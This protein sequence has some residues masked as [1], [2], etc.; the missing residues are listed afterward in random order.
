M[1]WCEDNGEAFI[2]GLPGNSVL[3]AM[4]E[5]A[6]DHL[7]LWHAV[8]TEAKLRCYTSLE[9]KARSWRGQSLQG[10]TP[11]RLGRP[12]AS[13]RSPARRHC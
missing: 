3:D 8:G 11:C 7:R 9:Y 12:C 10:L 13:R 6:C 1:E 5:E 4:V 2:F